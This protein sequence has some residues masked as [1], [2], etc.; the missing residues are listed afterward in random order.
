[1]YLRVECDAIRDKKLAASEKPKNS[2]QYAA[3]II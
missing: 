2:A 3:F 1:M